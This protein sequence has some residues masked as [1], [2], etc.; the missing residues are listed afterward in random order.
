MNRSQPQPT[1]ADGARV[2]PETSDGPVDSR[3]V[4]ELL[5]YV[6]TQQ[7]LTIQ[8]LAQTTRIRDIYL[9][10]ME[11]G[12]MEKLPGTAFVTGF[13]RLYVRA[14]G[15]PDRV[16]EPFISNWTQ[17][18]GN[19]QGQM[20]PPPTT[21]RRRPG[22]WFVLAGIVG[23]VSVLFLY[24]QYYADPSPEIAAHSLPESAPLR[25]GTVVGGALPEENGGSE[26]R[27]ENPSL[28]RESSP[29]MDVPSLRVAPSPSKSPASLRL[30]VPALVGNPVR[31][32]D[33]TP[34][35][36]PAPPDSRSSDAVALPYPGPVRETALG[37]SVLGFSKILS[38][39]PTPNTDWQR[40][41]EASLKA[42]RRRIAE[43]ERE[44][45][46]A[47]ERERI[48]EAERE[49]IAEVERERIAEAERERIAEAERKRIAERGSESAQESSQSY[50]DQKTAIRNRF[51]E[52]M[53]DN[54][55][56][57]PGS[58]R[59]VALLAKEL[60]WVQIQD[61]E[62]NVLK[63]M[64][65]Q[66]DD[67]FRVPEGAPFL[68]TLGNAGGITVQVGRRKLPDLGKPGDVIHDLDLT[69]ERLLQRGGL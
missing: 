11:A 34:L 25:V 54:G 50:G 30:D 61:R 57:R 29:V 65:M 48:A 38:K 42:E 53:P 27:Q 33:H 28:P 13:V 4:G 9:V 19:L 64:V 69:P 8:E 6:R 67:L 47:A 41:Q 16:V 31:L 58:P 40:E 17:E 5:R 36:R 15:L 1:D 18:Q 39:T 62:G 52:K 44:R 21:P 35:S 14:L 51:P 37:R 46:A 12:E 20:F 60:V 55:R 68:A 10:A 66:P 43:A 7:G 45:I 22:I 26:S 3:Q 32:S 59:E 49:R 2:G 63:D 23:L 56:H 24:E